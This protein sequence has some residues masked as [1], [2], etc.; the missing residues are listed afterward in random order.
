MAEGYTTSLLVNAQAILKETMQKPEFRHDPYNVI[1]LLKERGAGMFVGSELDRLVT[2]DQ[3]VLDTYIINKRNITVGSGRS[4]SHT[5]AAFGDSTKL[6]LSFDIVAAAFGISLKLGDRNMF[7]NAQMLASEIESALIAINNEHES[8]AGT[9]LNA[10]KTQSN[11]AQGSLSAFGSWNDTLKQW[12]IPVAKQNLFFEYIRQVMGYNNYTGMMDVILDPQADSLANQLR[13]QGNGNAT[14]YGW[15]FGNQQLVKSNGIAD[16]DYAGV[17]YAIPAGT[18]G[19]VARIPKQNKEGVDTRLFSYSSMI[20]PMT[21]LD[22]AVHEYEQGADNSSKG[23]ET[24]DVTFQYEGSNDKAFVKA[25]LSSAATDS[26][27]HKFVLV[28]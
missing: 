18:A 25:P 14:N 22:V 16:G 24:Q 4:D 20:D 2:S 19:I 23:S 27:I 13:E 17:A 1:R 3:R 26:T 6:T 12:E 10:S 7:A 5:T 8:D 28:G 9:W 15:Q 11:A 21:G